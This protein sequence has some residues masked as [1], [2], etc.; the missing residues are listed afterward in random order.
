MWAGLRGSTKIPFVEAVLLTPETFGGLTKTTL[1]S[2]AC[3]VLR[4]TTLANNTV[5]LK[6]RHS[7]GPDQHLV[8]VAQCVSGSSGE[9]MLLNNGNTLNT[10]S[11]KCHTS[12]SK[13]LVSYTSHAMA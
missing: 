10:I 8:R 9:N 6:H 1:V 13:R 2:G 5:E 12:V 3:Y 4:S 7:Y 11:S